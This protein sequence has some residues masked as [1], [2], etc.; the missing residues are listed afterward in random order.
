MRPGPAATN[1]SVALWDDHRALLEARAIL[2]GVARVR[3]YLAGVSETCETCET[4]LAS[5]VSHVSDNPARL[6]FAAPPGGP[7]GG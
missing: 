3:R 7:A 1:A 5:H 4:P 6:L 2:P